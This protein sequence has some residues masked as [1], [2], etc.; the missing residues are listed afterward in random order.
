METNSTIFRLRKTSKRLQLIWLLIVF[1]PLALFS[2]LSGTYTIGASQDYPDVQS[3]VAALNTNGVSGPVIFN[4]VPGTYDV[5]VTIN[6]IEGHS[7]TNTVTF[8]SSTQDTADVILEYDAAGLDD[9]YIFLL[10]GPDHLN[11]KHLTF[12]AKGETLYNTIILFDGLSSYVTF[13]HNA[14]YGNYSGGGAFEREAIILAKMDNFNNNVFGNLHFSHNY[15]YKGTHAIFLQGWNDN[16]IHGTLVEYNTFEQTGYSCVSCNFNSAPV[17]THNT[18]EAVSYGIKVS[19]DYGGGTYSYNKINS[20][21]WGMSILRLGDEGGRALISNNFVTIGQNG[22]SGDEGISIGN[23]IF[24]DVVNNSVYVFSNYFQASAFHSAQGIN[25]APTVTVKNNNFCC[26]NK[27]YAIEVITDNVISEMS[28]NNLY[29][30]DNYIA[31]WAYNRVFD[32]KGLQDLTGMQQNSLSVYPHYISGNDLH[33]IA[34]WLDG[35]GTSLA[36]VSD[37]ID[38]EVRS[39]TPDIGADE[40]VPDPAST[41][42]L[43]GSTEYTIGSGGTYPD[44]EE[45]MADA[46][47]RGISAPVTFGFLE[48]TYDGQFVM[49]SIPG[50]SHLNRVTIQSATANEDTALLTYTAQGL[51]D[52]FVFWLHGADFVTLRNLKFIS[53][54]T[55]YGRVINLYQGADSIIIENNHLMAPYRTGAVDNISGIYSGDSDFRSRIIRNNQIEGG[56]FGLYMRRDQNNFLYPTGA[57]IQD[58][59]FV[60]IGYSAM[61]LQFYDSPQILG[62]EIETA[63][64]GIQA[65]SCSN[66][67]RILKNKIHVNNGDGIYLSTSSG[68]E[69]NKGLIA[70]NFVHCGGSIE[71]QGI[72]LNNSANQLVY[73]NSVNVTNTNSNSRSLYISSGG[74]TSATLINN[75]FCN[76]G[77]GRALNVTAPATVLNCDYNAYYVTDD[78]LGWWG[79]NVLTLEALRALNSMDDHSV[80]GDPQFVSDTDLHVKAQMLD[81]AA[82]FLAEVPDDIDG[83]LRDPDYPDI[84]ADE[85]AKTEDFTLVVTDLQG[86]SHGVIKWGDYDNDG[87]LDL[88]QSGWIGETDQ[89]R[90]RIITNTGT[91]FEDSGISLTGL[92]GST[93]CSADWIDLDNDND[94]D[95]IVTGRLNGDELNKRT[96]LYRNDDGQFTLLEETGIPDVSSSC[97]KWAD[98]DRDGTYDLVLSGRSNTGDYNKIYL[99]SGGSFTPSPFF[100]MPTQGGENS[101]VD[102]DNDGDVDIFTCGS[103]HDPSVFYI[104][105]GDMTFVTVDTEIPE[106]GNVSVD[107]GDMDNDGDL[108]V[109]IM[110]K[111]ENDPVLRIYRNEGMPTNGGTWFSTAGNFT[112]TESGDL[113]WAD[114]DNDGDLDLAVTGNH[115]GYEPGTIILLND[116]GSFTEAGNNLVPLG[117]SALDWGDF[118]NDGD[119]DLALQGYAGGE[120]V[121]AIY[122]NNRESVNTIP[123]APDQLQGFMDGDTLVLSWDIAQDE[124]TP[125]AGLCYN[126]RLTLQGQ[127]RMVLSPMSEDG[128]LKKTFWGN[129]GNRTHLKLINPAS[130]T[131]LWSVQTIDQG[132]AASSFADEELLMVTAIPEEADESGI[133]V[134]PNPASDEVW[135]RSDEPGIYQIRVLELS[136]RELI[137]RLENLDAQGAVSLKLG[138]IKAGIYILEIRKGGTSVQKKL[139]IH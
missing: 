123:I 29:T 66:Q 129:A 49:K 64:K 88:L 4:I 73:H 25:T 35:K 87:D 63:S 56:A 134:F 83:D 40:F 136:G 106:L 52:N 124:E 80:F 84:G 48:G 130:G 96:V 50:S 58:N 138:S 135:I 85:V 125:P 75:I 23:S 67:L 26:E 102:I 71:V 16:Y 89:F 101:L 15:F 126:V 32:I 46:L 9:N 118:D 127:G 78:N 132:L 43:D 81:S 38:G 62:N 20:D 122:R 99:N 39:G 92:S 28:N 10:D 47:L 90:T 33:T 31:N 65:L 117:R 133:S 111:I 131:Y 72:F 3:A 24:T 86:L 107:W 97:V 21:N 115:A 95:I 55:Q 109:A 93:S 41:T 110:G 113:S 104:N 36:L 17:I 30:A 139:I 11:F 59:D 137:S 45:A 22:N 19:G 34:P 37:D 54:G 68:T 51:D 76:M 61:Y 6:H 8:Q 77:G 69:E 13:S 119:L 14:F 70:N 91:G 82:V 18:M 27:G 120:T 7:E 98:M 116:Q 114:Y 57:L 79:E 108:D 94:L 53:E 74:S 44:F 105:N 112:G 12:K 2:Q 100:L 42:P 103:N 1:C 128:F 121:T 5:H 60:N